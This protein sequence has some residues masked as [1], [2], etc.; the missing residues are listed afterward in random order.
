MGTGMGEVS[1][2]GTEVA[3]TPS[4]LPRVRL[5]SGGH[6]KQQAALGRVVFCVPQEGRKH[7]CELTVSTVYYMKLK[8]AHCKT[9]TMYPPP[10]TITER[11]NTYRKT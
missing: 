1:E 8:Y 2:T 7:F 6:T 4:L 5:L 10:T 11:K 3:H 9:Y